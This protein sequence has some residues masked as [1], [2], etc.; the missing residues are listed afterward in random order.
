[1]WGM[2][3]KGGVR[4][5]LCV[6]VAAC[7]VCSVAACGAG[8]GE[9]DADDSAQGGANAGVYAFPEGNRVYEGHGRD[10]RLTDQQMDEFRKA[11]RNRLFTGDYVAQVVADG[12]ISASEMNEADRRML[13]CCADKGVR[14]GTDFVYGKSGKLRVFQKAGNSMDGSGKTEKALKVCSTDSGWESLNQAYYQ[15]LRNP[16][17]LDLDPYVYQCYVDKGLLPRDST[18]EQFT[19]KEIV[20]DPQY[21]DPSN[22]QYMTVWECINDPLHTNWDQD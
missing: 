18:Y 7:V 14:E 5:L 19:K 1:M 9:G 16:K 6:V 13:A 15:A 22:P 3:A 10:A 4:R 21:S 20:L 17:G 12:V 2:M 11:L 8:K